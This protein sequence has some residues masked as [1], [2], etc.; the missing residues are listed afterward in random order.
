MHQ[1]RTT[2]CTVQ[3]APGPDLAQIGSGAEPGMAQIA[4][5]CC[6]CG[7]A[8]RNSKKA[9]KVC[10][11]CRNAQYCNAECQKEQAG[12]AQV[13]VLQILWWFCAFRVD[14]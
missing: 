3:S 12:L 6:N 11:K 5:V 4:L 10:G 13:V 8:A 2:W 7:K 9:L 1:L 14:R